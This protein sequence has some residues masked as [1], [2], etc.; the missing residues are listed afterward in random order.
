M[1]A[2]VWI[3]RDEDCSLRLGGGQ[4]SRKTPALS[5]ARRWPS[6]RAGSR[7]VRGSSSGMHRWDDR[8]YGRPPS[9]QK[10]PLSDPPARVPP[11]DTA[12]ISPPS[13][14]DYAPAEGL[15][16]VRGLLRHVPARHEARLRRADGRAVTQERQEHGLNT[17]P[18]SSQPP[19]RELPR[20][21]AASGR[22]AARRSPSARR[23]EGGSGRLRPP[24]R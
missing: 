16:G 3:D 2:T 7:A 1:R 23:D 24:P 12:Q 20:C 6:S 22:A 8:P 13:R 15:S 19:H 11:P 17:E 14:A 5:S 9:Q 10:R 18:S 21:A 4:L